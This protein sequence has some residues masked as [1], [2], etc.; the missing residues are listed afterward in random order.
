MFNLIVNA[1]AS[2]K[3]LYTAIFFDHQKGT[4][5]P[6]TSIR[7]R[8]Y[9]HGVSNG[10]CRI[11][12]KALIKWIY[13]FVCVRLLHTIISITSDSEV[14]IMIQPNYNWLYIYNFPSFVN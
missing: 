6:D 4:S 13:L 10:T 12:Q 3:R 11:C 14:L 9:F 1:G 8:S 5:V 2:F 7:I